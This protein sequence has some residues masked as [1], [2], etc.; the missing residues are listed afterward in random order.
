MWPSPY[1]D[2]LHPLTLTPLPTLQCLPTA[3]SGKRRRLTTAQHTHTQAKRARKQAHNTALAA[4]AVAH[5][6]PVPAPHGL[7]GPVTPAGAAAFNAAAF[8]AAI[9]GGAAAP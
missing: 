1:S 5:T 6:S 4:L 3:Y 2:E 8:G 7:A 9:A